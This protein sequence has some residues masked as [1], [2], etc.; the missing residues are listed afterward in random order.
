MDFEKIR[1]EV[2]KEEFINS[3]LT[4]GDGC[5]GMYGYYEYCS[6]SDSC[7]E[8]W[9][10]VIEENNIK[11]KD[12][13]TEEYKVIDALKVISKYCEEKSCP[14]CEFGVD[15]GNDCIIS[16]K[17]TSDCPC[18]WDIKP[19]ED[20]IKPMATIYLVEH[21]EGRKQYTFISDETL[22]VGDMVVCDTKF[23]HSYG[24]VVDIKQMADDGNKKCW[25]VK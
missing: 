22:S 21:I 2:T 1:K 16:Y 11:F 8:C 18:Y 4:I 14:L 5:P 3:Q 6:D 25:K 24:R 7:A 15:G 9:R 20:K 12:D 19:I 13:K 23:G 17:L 10:K